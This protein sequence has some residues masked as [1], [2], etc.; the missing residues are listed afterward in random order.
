MICFYMTEHPGTLWGADE[1]FVSAPRLDDIQCAFCFFGRIPAVVNTKKS[2]AVHCVLDNEEV[3]STTKTGGG[4]HIPEGHSEADQY[5]T[6]DEHRKNIYM[7]L[8]DSFMVSA[9]NAHALHPNHTDKT[10]PV[11]RPVLNGGIVIKYNANQKYCTDGVS[12]AIFKDIC[13]RAGGTISDLCEPFGYGRRLH[14]G[15]YFQY[16]GS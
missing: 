10:D 9:D 7:A 6:W 1:E 12:A 8:A 3:G 5:G 16:T 2:I 13:D 14:T 15:K 11:N 4:L